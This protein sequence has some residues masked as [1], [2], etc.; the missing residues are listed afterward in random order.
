VKKYPLKRVDNSLAANKPNKPKAN[1]DAD[2]ILLDAI[3][4][5]QGAPYKA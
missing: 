1:K 2:N 5:L 3:T 4:T